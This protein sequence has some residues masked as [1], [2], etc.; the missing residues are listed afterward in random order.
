MSGATRVYSWRQGIYS[1]SLCPCSK[2]PASLN[3]IKSIKQTVY[4]RFGYSLTIP[5]SCW[6]GVQRCKREISEIV[7]LLLL[8]LYFF[9]SKNGLTYITKTVWF[10]SSLKKR[11]SWWKT[12]FDYFYSYSTLFFELYFDFYQTVFYITISVILSF[13]NFMIFTHIFKSIFI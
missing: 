4:G 3:A 9:F 12:L 13:K 7:V 11:V 10:K 8:D 1:I 6:G 2:Q 5:R